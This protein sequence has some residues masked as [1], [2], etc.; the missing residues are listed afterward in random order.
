MKPV[1]ILD[2]TRGRL[3]LNGY[4]YYYF[5]RLCWGLDRSKMLAQ[6]SRSIVLRYTLVKATKLGVGK[7]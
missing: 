6:M 2:R 3:Y 1:D 7:W 5:R 4:G